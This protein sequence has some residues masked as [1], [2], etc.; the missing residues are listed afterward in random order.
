V[1]SLTLLLS[2]E[3]DVLCKGHYGVFRGKK[4]VADFICSLSLGL[5]FL[6]NISSTVMEL[7]LISEQSTR[8]N[9]HYDVILT[10]LLS[11]YIMTDDKMSL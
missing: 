5:P 8:N 6:T 4:E 10:L 1:K 9:R 7:L 3:A 2:L 11:M